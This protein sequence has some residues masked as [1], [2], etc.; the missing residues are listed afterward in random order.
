M[1]ISTTTRLHMPKAPLDTPAAGESTTDK[2]LYEPE[3][4]VGFAGG[5]GYPVEP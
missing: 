1:Y 5:I 4:A 2:V 3:A